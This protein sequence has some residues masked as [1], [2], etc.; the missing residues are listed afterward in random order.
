MALGTPF[1]Y[2][3]LFDT[4]MYSSICTWIYTRV[5]SISWL[6]HSPFRWLF[7]S[8]IMSILL[9]SKSERPWISLQKCEE[10]STCMSFRG[11]DVAWSVD[12]PLKPNRTYGISSIRLV[13]LLCN[14]SLRSQITKFPLGSVQDLDDKSPTVIWNG[15]QRHVF[16]TR[17]HILTCERR[18]RTP[19]DYSKKI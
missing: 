12:L 10:F 6:L 14:F 8:F 18:V 2:V 15:A 16:I 13:N 1:I 11:L 3:T 9:F 5:S 17:Y 4:V 19:T 7:S